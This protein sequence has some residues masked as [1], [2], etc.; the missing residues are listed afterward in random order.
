MS[1]YWPR[2]APGKFGP[3][4]AISPKYF[5]ASRICDLKRKP[6]ILWIRGG[7]DNMISDH[8]IIDYGTA[9]DMSLARGWPGEKE[10]PPQPMV[11][12]T[13]AVLER[14]QANGGS[15]KEVVITGAAHAPFLE[16]PDEFGQSLHLFLEGEGKNG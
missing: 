7:Q 16:K 13:R 4:N 10:Y 6:P 15:F 2:F 12:Q 1:S 3:L 14:Y 11:T 8:S 9:G 5:N